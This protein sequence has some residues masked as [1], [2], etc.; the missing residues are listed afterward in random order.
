MALIKKYKSGNKIDKTGFKDF[1]TTKFATGELKDSKVLDYINS[2]QSF[3]PDNKLVKNLYDEYN[4]TKPVTVKIEY[5]LKKDK[6]IGNLRQDIIKS[7]YGDDELSFFDEW[8]KDL[9]NSSRKTKL[10]QQINRRTGE[11]LEQQDLDKI[12]HK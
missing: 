5:D 6:N 4:K 10:S 1:I 8:E 2:D 7:Q 12:G 11:Y 3:D 9:D